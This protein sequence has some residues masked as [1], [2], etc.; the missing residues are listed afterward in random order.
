MIKAKVDAL[1]NEAREKG[2]AFV[3]DDFLDTENGEVYNPLVDRP[4]AESWLQELL[5]AL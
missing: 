4:N 1:L 2:L 3:E 5:I